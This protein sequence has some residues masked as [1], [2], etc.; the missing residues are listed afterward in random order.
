MQRLLQSRKH[1]HAD[2]IIHSLIHLAIVQVRS[3][4]EF[5]GGQLGQWPIGVQLQA[6]AAGAVRIDTASESSSRSA[7]TDCFGAQ[8]W[9]S[10]NDLDKSPVIGIRSQVT[11][12]A[13]H[14]LPERE[15][16]RSS[17]RKDLSSQQG[18]FTIGSVCDIPQ[19]SVER[20]YHEDSVRTHSAPPPI[21]G[22]KT[23]G[24]DGT[25][26]SSSGDG[27]RNLFHANSTSVDVAISKSHC[28]IASSSEG[29]C[30]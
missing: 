9:F 14:Q 3:V 7:V 2:V 24:S 16:S 22:W 11:V 12:H 25:A 17:G 29:R 1:S 5:P 26:G 20:G 30:G 6:S 18:S 10:R 27:E 23:A 28:P 8:N 4:E 19:Q 21:V 13:T 15:N